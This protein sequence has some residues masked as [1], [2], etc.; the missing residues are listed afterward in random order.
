MSVPS[1]FVTA[2]GNTSPIIQMWVSGSGY[3]IGNMVVSPSDFCEYIRKTDG[4]GATDP[5]SDT[6]NW[7]PSGARARKS[8]QRITIAVGAGT[9]GSATGAISSVNTAKTTIKMLGI[10][11]SL[12]DRAINGR[13]ELTDSTTVTAYGFDSINAATVGAEIEETY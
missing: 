2:A 6:T 3:Y 1:G 13:V 5:S 4:F 9:G 7:Q 12:N 11:N 10:S 8:L